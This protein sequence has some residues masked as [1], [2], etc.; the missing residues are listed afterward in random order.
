LVT[1]GPPA[2]AL[3]VE[4][5]DRES[6][7]VPPRRRNDPL[8]PTGLWTTVIVRS[9]FLAAA[10][11]FAFAVSYEWM[12][13]DEE[14]ARGVALATLVVV[15][16]LMAFTCRS[17]YLPV[18]KLAPVGNWQLIAGIAFSLVALLM[19]LTVPPLQDA[20]ETHSLET[21]EWAMVLGFSTVA[22]LLIETTKI[23][24]WRIRR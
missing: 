14:S 20:F 7:R 4:P 15:H 13:R 3:A 11:L 23:W 16:V 8:L 1:D 10:V 9:I 5:A 21:D 22:L 2:L 12:D 6:A 19:V 17:L 24:P 18:W